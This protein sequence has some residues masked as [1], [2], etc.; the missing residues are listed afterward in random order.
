MSLQAFV[1]FLLPKEDHFYDFVEKQAK[2]AHDAA[3]A[4]AE[5]K[6]ENTTAEAVRKKVQDIEHTG[7]SIVHDM[8]DALARSFVTP[9]DREDLQPGFRVQAWKRP[10]RRAK[11]ADQGAR[12]R[13]VVRS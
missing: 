7:D 8:D 6:K 5:F 9:I 4:L 1:R 12:K 2:V 3:L 10:D 13:V 11:R